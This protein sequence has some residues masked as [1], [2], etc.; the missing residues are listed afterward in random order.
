MINFYKGRMYNVIEWYNYALDICL[1]MAETS[2]LFIKPAAYSPWAHRSPHFSRIH[3]TLNVTMWDLPSGITVRVK[4]SP[5]RIRSWNFPQAP[6]MVFTHALVWCTI[7]M[8]SSKACMC[9]WCKTNVN[10][11]LSLTKSLDRCI[12]DYRPL[13]FL[14]LEHLL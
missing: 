9:R 4:C 2:L 1:P 3:L 11:L 8:S 10:I 12:L 13:A 7:A 5:R 6:F 14:F